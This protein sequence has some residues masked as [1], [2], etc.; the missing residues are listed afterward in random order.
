MSPYFNTTHLPSLRGRCET[1]MDAVKL[2]H[3]HHAW[4][5]FVVQF[6]GEDWHQ[7][8]GTPKSTTKSTSVNVQI[9]LC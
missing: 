3:R 9:A 8:D 2:A 4:V 5:D 7:H 1:W 6:E